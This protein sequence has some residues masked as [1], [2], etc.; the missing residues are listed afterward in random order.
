MADR[1]H[2]DMLKNLPESELLAR[3]AALPAPAIDGDASRRTH[4]RA[5]A[6]FVRNADTPAWLASLA[7]LY[8]RVEPVMATGVAAVYLFWAF[9]SAMAL[10]Q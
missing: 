5:R 8:S 7:R 2:D 9:Q 1:T 3:L 4:R 10:Y 6:A